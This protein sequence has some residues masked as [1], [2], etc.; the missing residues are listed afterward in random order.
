MDGPAPK[1]RGVKAGQR[2]VEPHLN[3]DPRHPAPD[4]AVDHHRAL[5]PAAAPVGAM[6][7]F[8]V[9]VGSTRV[10]GLAFSPGDY[11][12]ASLPRTCAKL[13]SIMKVMIVSGVGCGLET[14]ESDATDALADVTRPAPMV[15]T[16]RRCGVV[17][18]IK[19]YS[20]NIASST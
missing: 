1:L 5:G 12:R 2:R 17:P 20:G 10:A 4:V 9:T 19:R 14:A 7:S 16:I 6:S 13:A 18:A 11:L 15:A 8:A 3:V